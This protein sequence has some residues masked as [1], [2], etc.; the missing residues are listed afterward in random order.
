MGK[1]SLDLHIG[2]LLHED[3]KTT[4]INLSH[5]ELESRR[6]LMFETSIT[7]YDYYFGLDTE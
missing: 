7:N 5:F 3:E 4:Q 1:I 2:W 6:K